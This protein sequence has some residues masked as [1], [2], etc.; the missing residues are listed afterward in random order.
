MT[1]MPEKTKSTLLEKLA[2]VLILLSIVLA[3]FVGMLWQKVQN[4]EKGVGNTTTTTNNGQTATIDLVTIKGLWDKNLIK[5][6]DK[7]K[8]VLFVEIVDPS[9]PFCHIAGG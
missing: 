9:C 8:K 1:G 2:P 3:F 4:L 5:F 7:N 6:G